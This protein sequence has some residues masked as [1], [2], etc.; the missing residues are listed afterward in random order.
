MDYEDFKKEFMTFE[1]WNKNYMRDDG[2]L[3]SSGKDKIHIELEGK[4]AKN[5]AWLKLR[6]YH[7]VD[8]PMHY[9]QGSQEVI[10]TI[11]EAISNAPNGQEAFLQGQVLK[12]ML[13]MWLKENPLQDAEKARWYLDRLITKLQSAR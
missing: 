2:I 10:D 9:T 12:Y 13:R 8:H 6:D 7:A 3:G 4:H 11:E 5:D 1:D